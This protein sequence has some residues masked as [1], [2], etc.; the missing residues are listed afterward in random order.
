MSGPGFG[1]GFAIGF[2]G[3]FLSISPGLDGLTVH[4]VR[5]VVIAL[6]TGLLAARYGDRV[7]NWLIRLVDW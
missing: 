7:W 2:L 5:A 3:A 1:W 4:M 6:V